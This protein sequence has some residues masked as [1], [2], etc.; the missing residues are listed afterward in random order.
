[1]LYYIC[2]QEVHIIHHNGGH[3]T[4]V[5]YTGTFRKK[6]GTERLMNYI[7]VLD[8]PKGMVSENTRR[9][10][11]SADTKREIVYDVNLNAIRTFNHGTL[12]GEITSKFIKKNL[13]N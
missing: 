7:N 13:T 5:Q 12:I 4:C 1:M 10:R 9:N 6:D 11:L 2:E 3:M 8:L